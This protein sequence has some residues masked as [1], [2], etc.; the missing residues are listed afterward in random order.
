[1]GKIGH[2][3]GKIKGQFFQHGKTKEKSQNINKK[4][5]KHPYFTASLFPHFPRKTA[6]LGKNQWFLGKNRG[7]IGKNA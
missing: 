5:I 1:M 2:F 6:V 7:I 4:P 3:L